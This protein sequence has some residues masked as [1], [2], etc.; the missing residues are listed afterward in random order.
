MRAYRDQFE[1]LCPT[2]DLT[3][4]GVGR[5]NR[6]RKKHLYPYKIDN[7]WLA[8]SAKSLNERVSIVDRAIVKCMKL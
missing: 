4:D 8:L 5:S 6:Q 7:I 3:F 2:V 1:P